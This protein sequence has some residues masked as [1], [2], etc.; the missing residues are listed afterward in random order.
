M[1]TLDPARPLTQ[2]D[3]DRLEALLATEGDEGEA[4]PLDAL[5]GLFFAIACGPEPVPSSQW[6]PLALG[7]ARESVASDDTGDTCSLLVRFYNQCVAD[8]NRDSFD[9]ILYDGLADDGRDFAT[10]CGG[11]LDGV[12]LCEVDWF[13]RGD[14]DEVDE[15]LYPFVVLAGE[16]PARERRSFKPA[17]WRSLVHAC[18]DGLADAIVD[19]REYWRVMRAPPETLRRLTPKTGR[20]DPCP[21]GSGKKYKHCCG[22]PAKLH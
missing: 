19:V 16:L 3:L 10:W 5:Q 4:M 17:E 2:E 20:N 14:P 22:A 12:Q 11:F 13:E 1:T 7:E 15:L 6:M 9:L 21:C 18:Q 8:V